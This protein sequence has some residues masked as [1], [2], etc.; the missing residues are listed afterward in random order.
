MSGLRVALAGA[1]GTIGQATERALVSA[2]ATVIALTREDFRAPTSLADK[3]KSADAVISC[4][5]SRTGAPRD[6]WA[7]DHDANLAL[8]TATETAQVNR[9][10]LLSAICVQ[11]PKLAFQRAKHAFEMKLQET[12]L[13]WT[14]IRPTAFFKSLSGQV[15][16]VKAGKPYWVFGNGRRTACK[17]ISNRDLASF[18]V[19]C[20]QET[21]SV[22]KVLPIG[23][24]GPAITPLEQAEYLFKT[25]QKPA[26]IRHMPVG[27][28]AAAARVLDV[29]GAL[30]PNVQDKAEF[31][32]TAHYYAS[33]SMLV[34]DAESAEYRAEATPEFG[35][36][37]L[38][39]HY[40]AVLSGDTHAALGAHAMF[41]DA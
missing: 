15:A 40:D 13:A 22:R 33:E 7:V 4:I 39:A 27:I 25:L 28:F 12:D 32:R 30:F 8:M 35:T 16:R 38:F 20:L 17:P 34:W 24:P 10:I 6:A 14:I 5:A 11:K 23:G 41:G 36:E 18:V 37:T 3:L 29:A 31:A 26:K 19:C 9:F 1:T 21:K 2:G